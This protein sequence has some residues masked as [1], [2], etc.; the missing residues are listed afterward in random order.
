MLPDF[1]VRQRDYLLEIARLLTEELDLEKLLARILKSAIEMLAGQA[2]LDLVGE[3]GPEGTVDAPRRV[4]AMRE[5]L[6]TFDTGRWSGDRDEL[7][8][9]VVDEVWERITTDRQGCAGSK[10]PEFARCPFQA[11]RQRVKE[12]DLVIANHDLVLSAID[13]DGASVLPSPQETIYVFDEAH[14]LAAKAV[15]HFSARHALRG[16]MEWLEGP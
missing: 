16:A 15:E 9:P 12:A 11:A 4:A 13:M 7:P 5:L 2:G 14:S 6:V 3:G 10:C 1:R 8:L